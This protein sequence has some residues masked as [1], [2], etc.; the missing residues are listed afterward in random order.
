MNQIKKFKNWLNKSVEE[1]KT[2][3]FFPNRDRL[4]KIIGGLCLVVF[5]IAMWIFYI[6]PLET[7]PY[8]IIQHYYRL[9]PFK[10]TY[11][12]LF[13]IFVVLFLLS[14]FLFTYNSKLKN[15]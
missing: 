13:A 10:M 14:V 9:E 12:L 6:S 11:T 8:E 15:K 2:R 4:G 3:I 5:S 1:P 7:T